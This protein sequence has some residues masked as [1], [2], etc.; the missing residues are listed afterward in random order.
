MTVLALALVAVLL[1]LFLKLLNV[2]SRPQKPILYCKD[3]NLLTTV[4][5][6]TPSLEALYTP[7]SLW[8]FSG[9]VQTVIHSII[10]RVQSPWPIGDRIELTLSDNTTLTYDL[11][12]PFNV[13]KDDITLAIVPGICNTSESVY[14]RTFVHH[15]QKLGL[16]CAVLNHVGALNSVT[17]TASRVFTYGYTGDL[18]EMLNHLAKK[19]TQSKIIC[20]GYSMGGNLVTKYMGETSKAKPSNIVGAVS[21]CQGYNAIE[22]TKWMLQWQNF[23]R[24]YLYAMTE[25]MKS[26]ILRHRSVLLSEKA[27]AE[28]GLNEKEIASAATLPEL[29][30]AYTRKVY[31]FNSVDELYHWSSCVNYLHNIEHPT[32]FINS[33]DDPLVPE[34][35]LLPIRKYA[36]E[37]EKALLIEVAHGGHLGFYEGGI[38]CPN[39]ESWL[40]R[41]LVH[42]VQS[43]IAL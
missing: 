41:T 22:G 26:I 20:I 31:K 30:D 33:L 4:L 13:T 24:L 40:D 15:A 1:C 21:I 12:Q 18:S 2:N 28:F 17:L 42:L 9:H 19:Y 6:L 25:A 38:I 16:R 10:G 37:H 43:L 14:V 11:Y 39:Q 35:L 32:I 8:G 34:D 23:R 29:D 36:S 27:K 3:E 7:T 5:K